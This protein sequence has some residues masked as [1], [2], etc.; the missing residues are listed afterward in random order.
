VRTPLLPS[1]SLLTHPFT[2]RR[3]LKLEDSKLRDVQK[4]RNPN[5]TAMSSNRTPHL[6]AA[7]GMTSSLI[8]TVAVSKGGPTPASNAQPKFTPYATYDSASGTSL[9][10]IFPHVCMAD[11]CRVG[12]FSP[13]PA[14]ACA[15][16]EIVLLVCP[17]P[18]IHPCGQVRGYG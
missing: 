10:V 11:S 13:R 16:A 6:F 1:C 17:G 3:I 8:S 9:D 7:C 14:A 12:T 5:D 2:F 18:S 4:S 15:D